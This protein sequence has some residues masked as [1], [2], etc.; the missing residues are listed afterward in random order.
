M[1]ASRM[2]SYRLQLKSRLQSQVQPVSGSGV[3]GQNASVP[4]AGPAGVGLTVAASLMP[5]TSTPVTVAA[6][7][8]NP[9]PSSDVAF[10][11]L[12]GVCSYSCSSR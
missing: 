5:A 11:M 3:S 6:T 8:P 12:R 4:A 10:L 2:L 9:T 1:Q 7:A